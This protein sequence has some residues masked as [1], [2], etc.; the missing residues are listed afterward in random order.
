MLGA[1]NKIVSVQGFTPKIENNLGTTVP[2]TGWNHARYPASIGWLGTYDA[3]SAA[4][5]PRLQA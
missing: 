4:A 1:P 5:E 2:N 3:V